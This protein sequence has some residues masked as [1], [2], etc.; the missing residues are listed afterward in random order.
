MV[1]RS[2]SKAY[3]M[4]SVRVR[5]EPF[6]K[7]HA[8]DRQAPAGVEGRVAAVLD[9]PAAVQAVQHEPHLRVGPFP[10]RRDCRHTYTHTHTHIHT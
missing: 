5:T 7:V 10:V 6:Y 4:S 9:L 2:A 3:C 8:M 1:T